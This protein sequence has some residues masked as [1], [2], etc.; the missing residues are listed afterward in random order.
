MSVWEKKAMLPTM[1]NLVAS[2]GLVKSFFVEI[3][4]ERMSCRS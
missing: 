3:V 4:C 2:I 1:L